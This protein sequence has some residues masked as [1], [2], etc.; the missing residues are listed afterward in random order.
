MIDK[1]FSASKQRN[2]QN[3]A[4][5]GGKYL[6]GSNNH[7]HGYYKAADI[8]VDSALNSHINRDRDML[9]FPIVLNYRHYVELSLKDL[10]GKSEDCYDALEQTSSTYGS[11]KS[12]L[13]NNLDNHHLKPL[14]NYLTERLLLIGEVGFEESIR[15]TVLDIHKLDPESITFRYLLKKKGDLTLPEQE[16][17]DLKNIQERMKAVENSFE[18]AT[19]G[20]QVK[21]DLALEWLSIQQKQMS[22]FETDLPRYDFEGNCY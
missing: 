20:L 2:W 9:F 13:K 19:I 8:L 4:M 6:L 16:L 18:G 3:E 7:I 10:I 21:T 22:E 14:L 17:Y 1:I 5:A 12:R 11:L 15:E